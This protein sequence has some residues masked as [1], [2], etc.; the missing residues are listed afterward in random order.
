M[1]SAVKLSQLLLSPVADQLGQ[2][3][4]IIVADGSLQSIPFTALPDFIAQGTSIPEKG[5]Q[6][7]PS[8]GKVNY[9]PLLIQHEIINL[10]SVTVLANQRQAL[11]GRKHASKTLAILANPVFDANDETRFPHKNIVNNLDIG[12]QIKES[13]LKQA[14]RNFN[15]GSWGA[16]PGTV[17][18]A[19]GILKLVP[20]NE[21]LQAFDFDANYNWV[22]SKQLSQYRF[23]HFAT[24][25][26]AD[27]NNPELSGIVLSLVDKTGKS[28][29]GYLQLGD[30]FNLNFP[31]DLVVLSACET[32]LGKD[33]SG[34]GLVGLTRGLMYAGAE[35]VAVSLWRVDDDATAKLM[36]EF[37]KQ[38][39]Q[40]GKSPTAALREA[41]LGL[42]KDPNL[43][44]PLYWAA[45]TLQGEWR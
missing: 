43:N 17:E 14:A 40:K 21:T 23:L 20:A 16:L 8:S 4:L 22:I 1:Q 3:R 18:E 28:I 9:Q 37:Y 41:Q 2:K 31:S 36:Q 30:I 13:Q 38:M 10:P 44:K 35:R 15:R 19:K 5:K 6:D 7:N 42:W 33:V 26:F 24:H 29:D 25:G 12:N 45:F 32:G 27:P 11:K 34:E 39:L